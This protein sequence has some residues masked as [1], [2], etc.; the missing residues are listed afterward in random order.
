[1]GSIDRLDGRPSIAVSDATAT[2]DDGKDLTAVLANR[3]R[4]ERLDF[5][6][7]G[8]LQKTANGAGLLN[9]G[10][11]L[12][13][14]ARLKFKVGR[15]TI[16]DIDARCARAISEVMAK[17]QLA[18]VRAADAQIGNENLSE[19]VSLFLARPNS[20]NPN[21]TKYL[22]P[23]GE[24]LTIEAVLQPN[25]RANLP[26]IL[27]AGAA[28]LVNVA[29]QINDIYDE[30]TTRLPAYRTFVD[31]VTTAVI[32]AAQ[33]ALRMDLKLS[34][35]V[36]G[37]LVQCDSDNGEVESLIQHMTLKTDRQTLIDNVVW[38]HYV[39][40]QALEHGGALGDTKAYAWIDFQRYGR[41]TT[42]LD[43]V[44]EDTGL[45]FEFDVTPAGLTNP[46]IRVVPVQ[47]ER[48]AGATA[49]QLPVN[50]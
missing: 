6:I 30:D 29:A 37:L 35:K 33:G 36:S 23:P 20:L 44:S 12:G 42:W 10:S 39:E 22:D 21:E 26:G 8:T 32:A 7:T 50:G 46:F 47:F 16:V 14:V 24:N 2:Q 4:R 31:E 18:A 11:I 49:P 3:R 9:R 34:R 40:A 27:N 1:M 19:L 28:T 5:R 25:R 17:T 13:A 38:T 48:I 41:N 15:K 43:P 45:R